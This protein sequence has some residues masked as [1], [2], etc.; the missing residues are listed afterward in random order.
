M[1]GTAIL[2]SQATYASQT[3]PKLNKSTTKTFSRAIGRI[4]K[5]IHGKQTSVR[6]PSELR[7]AADIGLL[8]P[9][10]L[11]KQQRLLYYRR[12]IEHAPAALFALLQAESG[13]STSYSAM[14]KDDIKWM[15]KN[16]S[17]KITDEQLSTDPATAVSQIVNFE[18]KQ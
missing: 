14:L 17:Q 1:I 7:I 10:D 11:L 15:R 5:I 18:P 8:L 12:A 4:Y 16:L 9:N 2:L 13:L 6:P 3:W